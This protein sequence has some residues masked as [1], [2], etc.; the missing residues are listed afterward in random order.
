M[1]YAYFMVDLRF[2]SLRQ[3]FPLPAQPTVRKLGL[4]GPEVRRGHGGRKFTCMIF[5]GL[6]LRTCDARMGAR[7]GTRAARKPIA[8][9]ESNIGNPPVPSDALTHRTS[10]RME[11]QPYTRTP[12]SMLPGW[13]RPLQLLKPPLKDSSARCSQP[14]RNLLPCSSQSLFDAAKQLF[15]ALALGCGTCALVILSC[16]MHRCLRRHGLWRKPIIPR[17]AIRDTS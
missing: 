5:E 15:S 16:S 2:P 8:N 3:S 12:D 9:H 14:E 4:K 10:C 7:L 17:G 1:S 13:P 6:M 11:R